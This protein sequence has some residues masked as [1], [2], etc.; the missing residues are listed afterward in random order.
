[1]SGDAE[2]VLLPAE[3]KALLARSWPG[4]VRELRNYIEERVVLAH[5]RPGA[6]AEETAQESYKA[7]KARA[8]DTF[9]RAFLS[10][11][12]LRTDGN[13]T[14]AAAMAAMDRVNLIKLLRKHGLGRH[15]PARPASGEG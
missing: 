9:E 3:A 14:H 6:P 1:M 15:A 13:V 4:N 8:L 2:A 5:L 12:M 10:A 11:L 7:A